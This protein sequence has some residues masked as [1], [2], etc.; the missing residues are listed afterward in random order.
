MNYYNKSKI[1]NKKSNEISD[2][3]WYDDPNILFNLDRIKDFFP[4]TKMSLEEQLNAYTRLTFYISIIMFFYSGNYHYLFIFIITIIFTFLI[5]KNNFEKKNINKDIEKFG[6]YYYPTK[7]IYP[8]KNNPFMNISMEDYT[9]NPNRQVITK[10]PLLCNRN[11]SDK[12]N[13][14]FNINL[15]KDLDDIFDKNNSQR[16]FYTTPITTIPNDQGKFAKWLYNKNKTC[17]EGNG[18][19]CVINNYTPPYRT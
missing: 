15:Y 7:Y 10:N 9:K 12:V 3:F 1:K 5:H 16:Q 14:K 2:K 4:H 11:I 18:Y 8:T 6:N 17:K 13:D 19:Q